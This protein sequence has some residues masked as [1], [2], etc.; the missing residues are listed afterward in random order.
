MSPVSDPKNRCNPA[1]QLGD[2]ATLIVD[3]LTKTALYLSTQSPVNELKERNEIRSAN[4]NG[5]DDQ[6]R[7]SHG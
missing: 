6:F 3:V 5:V 4:A 2:E 7:L 1:G